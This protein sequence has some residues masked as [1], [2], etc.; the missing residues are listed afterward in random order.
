MSDTVSKKKKNRNKSL[1][2]EKIVSPNMFHS[3]VGKMQNLKILTIFI[4]I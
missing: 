4:V 2:P 3:P 1:F